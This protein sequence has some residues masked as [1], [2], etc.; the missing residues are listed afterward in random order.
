MNLTDRAMFG[1]TDPMDTQGMRRLLRRAFYRAACGCEEYANLLAQ[2]R[3]YI[4]APAEFGGRPDLVDDLVRAEHALI[5]LSVW[6][7]EAADP[8][9]PAEHPLTAGGDAREAVPQ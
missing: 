9:L 3:S 7:W 5:K 8:K 4:D 6:A 1:G 2:V